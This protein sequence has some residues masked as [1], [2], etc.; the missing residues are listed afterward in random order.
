MM[1]EKEPDK[2]DK[3]IA[4][5][6][7]IYEEEGPRRFR[8]QVQIAWNRCDDAADSR[9][10]FAFCTPSGGS[11]IRP[12]GLFCGCIT[13]VKDDF[14]S[15]EP[16]EDFHVAWTNELTEQIRSDDRIPRGPFWVKH[17]DQLQVFAEYQRL[18]DSTIRVGVD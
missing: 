17:P 6:T 3:A 12:D 5:L 8:S 9:C 18:M 15:G 14:I 11:H 7:K 16:E 13:Q 2:Y 10:L 4:H 1:K